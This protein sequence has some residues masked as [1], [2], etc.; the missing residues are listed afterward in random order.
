MRISD[1]SSDVCSSDLRHR[2]LVPAFAGSIPAAPASNCN[3][4]VGDRA[5]ALPCS[6]TYSD[7]APSLAAAR[8]PNVCR[9]PVREWSD[10]EHVHV[11]DNSDRTFRSEEHTSELPSLTRISYAVFAFKN[12]KQRTQ[13][14]NQVS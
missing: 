14:C 9:L 6:I 2:F 12:K 7:K 13:D 10:G 5:D 8:M 11:G 3:E 4:T 1:W